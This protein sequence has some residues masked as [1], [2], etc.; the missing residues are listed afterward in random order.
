MALSSVPEWIAKGGFEAGNL[1][2]SLDVKGKDRDWRTW[3]TTGWL[4]LSNGLVK[5]KGSAPIQD[6][7]VRLLLARD[8]AE[9]KRL[10]FRLQ[11]SDVTLEGTIRNWIE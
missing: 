6:L 3:K 2:L 9:L 11:D 7:Y 1:E 10:S 8:I 4:A 5:A